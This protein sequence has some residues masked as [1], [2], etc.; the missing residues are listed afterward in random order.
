[1][2]VAS[3]STPAH[4]QVSQYL[5][6]IQYEKRLSSRTH[7]LYQI[8]LTQLLKWAEKKNV[9]LINMQTHDVLHWVT[10]SHAKG[11]SA[12]S[13]ALVLSIWR[14]FYK[15]LI[16]QRIATFNPV[17]DVRAPKSGAKLPKALP[18]DDAVQLAQFKGQDEQSHFLNARDHAMIELLYG[19]GIRLSELLSIQLHAGPQ[20]DNWIDWSDA[21]L[22]LVGK[23][24]KPRTVPLGKK[25]LD[26]LQV[27]LEHRKQVVTQSPAL[28]IGQRGQALTPQHIRSRLRQWAQ[29]AGLNQP[30]HPHMLRHSFAS[31]LLQSSGDLRGV[32]E[33]LGHASIRSTQIYTRLDFQH[34]AH[35]Y[36]QAHPRARKEK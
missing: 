15:W 7:V 33:L 27:W 18:V 22:H 23:G 36:D 24:K 31:H 14:S 20:V 13:I 17:Q 5:D 6:H 34:L 4:L 11:A 10:Q 19:C 28:W 2:S 8:H 21:N 1:M 25:A 26:A 29:Q 9:A 32:Q 12:S 30:L 35:V 16:Q 3:V